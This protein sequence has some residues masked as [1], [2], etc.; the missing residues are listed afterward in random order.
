[1]IYDTLIHIYKERND[2]IEERDDADEEHKEGN[3]EHWHAA[4][5]FQLN[6]THTCAWKSFTWQAYCDW[7]SIRGD[8]NCY[9]RTFGCKHLQTLC[10]SLG[11]A[12]RDIWSG[13][14]KVSIEVSES[15]RQ[16]SRGV[17]RR[18]AECSIRTVLWSRHCCIW[19][20][21]GGTLRT[22]NSK[23]SKVN[24]MQFPPEPC[25]KAAILYVCI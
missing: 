9:Y 5:V 21:G 3:T 12:M 2:Y 15:Q 25:N 24:S 23:N 1:M 11:W 7:R 4:Q 16:V 14:R 13:F 6:S 19:S 17:L 22:K 8:G 10:G 18:G 20:S